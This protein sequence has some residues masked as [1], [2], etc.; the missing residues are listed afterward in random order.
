MLSNIPLTNISI[1]LFNLLNYL[2][3]FLIQNSPKKKKF[4]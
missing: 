2:K 1:F 3:N 4:K